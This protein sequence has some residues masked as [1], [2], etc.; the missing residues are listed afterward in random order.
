MWVSGGRI[1]YALKVTDP[2]TIF[3]TYNWSGKLTM[4]YYASGSKKQ[5]PSVIVLEA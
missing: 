2:N 5:E 3:L 4:R 1:Y